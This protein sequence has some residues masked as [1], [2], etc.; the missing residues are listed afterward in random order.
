[1]GLYMP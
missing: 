1:M